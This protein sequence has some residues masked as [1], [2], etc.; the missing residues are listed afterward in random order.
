MLLKPTSMYYSLERKPTKQTKKHN[1]IS[2]LSHLL[3]EDYLPGNGRWSPSGQHEKYFS[4]VWTPHISKKSSPSVWSQPIWQFSAQEVNQKQ[5]K[6]EFLQRLFNLHVSYALSQPEWI[7]S[8]TMKKSVTFFHLCQFKYLTNVKYLTLSILCSA[9]SSTSAVWYILHWL[10]DAFTYWRLWHERSPGQVLSSAP[11]THPL[12]LPRHN[13]Q[14]GL[15][16]L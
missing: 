15:I 7:I 3:K 8:F 13:T 14:R 1:S 16:S 2:C 5:Y 6:T 12:T 9:N 11:H 4:C 10:Y